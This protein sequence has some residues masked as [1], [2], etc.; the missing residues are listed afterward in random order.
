MPGILKV[1]SRSYV[2]SAILKVMILVLS[3]MK[4]EVNGSKIVITL[5]ETLQVAEF[6]IS[7]RFVMAQDEVSFAV[8][9]ASA[10]KV[11]FI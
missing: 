10:G 3:C 4:S 6:W 5:P 1:I 7:D 9:D 11:T 8:I 2:T